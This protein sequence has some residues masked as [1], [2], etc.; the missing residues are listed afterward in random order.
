M[1]PRDRFSEQL[2]PL[3]AVASVAAAYPA[4]DGWFDLV[5]VD[6][7]CAAFLV[8]A[9]ATA[10]RQKT[11]DAGAAVVGV[12]LALAF[13]TKQTGAVFA[14]WLFAVLA[15]R[16]RRA[17]IIAAAVAGACVAV[18][19]GG[20]SWATEG[21][22]WTATVGAMGRHKYLSSLAWRAIVQLFDNQPWSALAIPLAAAAIVRRRMRYRTVVWLG[23]WLVALPTSIV[24][25]AKIAAHVNNLLMALLFAGPLVALLSCDLSRSLTRSLTGRATPYVAAAMVLAFGLRWDHTY[26]AY[27]PTAD[28]RAQVRG[29]HTAVAALDGDVVMPE[30]PFLPVMHGST[31]SQ[32]ITQAYYDYSA[33]PR[34]QFDPLACGERITGQWAILGVHPTPLLRGLVHRN[35]ELRRHVGWSPMTRHG[36]RTKPKFLLRRRPSYRKRNQRIVFDFESGDF[37]GFA[38]SGT[39]FEHGPARTSHVARGSSGRFFVTSFHK[40]DH[41]RARGRLTSP[42]FIVDRDFISLSVAGGRKG[43]QV[44]LRLLPSR[45]TWNVA[46]GYESSVMIPHVWNARAIRGTRAQLVVIDKSDRG[47]GHISMDDVVLFDADPL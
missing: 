8:L 4:V 16:S 6:M 18:I 29:L 28:D 33:L 20:L 31:L 17:G 7:L 32:P 22:Y 41:D 47:W 37:A 19:V 38:R 1:R 5:R 42:S 25:S 46:V 43:V 14:P 35:F 40:T 13:I 34:A 15:Y 11:S 26:P 36:Y 45:K 27:L 3:L 9:A 2:L 21:W 23:M 39:A 10:A 30:H 12:C 44:E 24:A